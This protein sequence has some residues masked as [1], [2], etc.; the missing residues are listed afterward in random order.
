MPCPFGDLLRVHFVRAM[1]EH[2]GIELS[3][4]GIR[5][6]YAPLYDESAPELGERPTFRLEV[7]S[8]ALELI[9][10]RNGVV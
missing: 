9:K 2:N 8:I 1:F 10:R 7:V 6:G 3:L 4:D 5:I